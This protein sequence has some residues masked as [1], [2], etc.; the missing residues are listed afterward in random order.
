MDDT[1]QLEEDIKTCRNLCEISLYI[2]KATNRM[3]LLP[4]LLETLYQEVQTIVGEYC[5]VKD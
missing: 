4:T 5:V 1:H 3:D 2:L